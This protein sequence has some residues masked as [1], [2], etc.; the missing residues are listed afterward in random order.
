MNVLSYFSTNPCERFRGFWS[1]RCPVEIRIWR[2]SG[3]A[4]WSFIDFFF[5]LNITSPEIIFIFF[6]SF[7][8]PNFCFHSPHTTIVHQG[9]RLLMHSSLLLSG[10]LKILGYFYVTPNFIRLLRVVI[11]PSVTLRGENDSKQSDEFQAI[12]TSQVIFIRVVQSR[13]PVPI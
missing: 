9:S 12:S 8:P 10:L 3:M 1:R 11:T 2:S 6:F 7:L 5:E 13:L 4:S